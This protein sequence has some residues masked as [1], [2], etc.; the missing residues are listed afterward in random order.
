MV[1]RGRSNDF[2][3][4]EDLNVVRGRVEGP[5]FQHEGRTPLDY[6]GWSQIE[7]FKSQLN[8]FWTKR[9]LCKVEVMVSLGEIAQEG[10]PGTLI[11]AVS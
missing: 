8:R 6:V 4:F 2:D 11:L 9:G 3:R 5:R 7:Q 10:A 1:L